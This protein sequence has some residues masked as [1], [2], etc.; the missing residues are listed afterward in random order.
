MAKVRALEGDIGTF[1]N[2][3]LKNLDERQRRLFLA[4]F[5][6]TVQY[7]QWISPSKRATEVR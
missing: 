7:P 4:S 1:A 2:T 5:A 3:M 6:V